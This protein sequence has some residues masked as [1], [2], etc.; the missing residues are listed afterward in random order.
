MKIA[1]LLPFAENFS[2]EKA[3]AIALYCR[4]LTLE[5]EADTQVEIYGKKVANAFADLPFK[6]LKPS[7]FHFKKNIALARS[8]L[9]EIEKDKPDIIE[10]HNRPNIFFYLVKKTKLPTV[11]VLHN[12]PLSMKELKSEPSR[13]KLLQESAMVFCVSSFVKNRLLEGIEDNHLSNKVRVVYN[14]IK[15]RRPLFPQ[16]SKNI[17]FVGR[18]IEEKGALEFIQG[19]R[20]V[21]NQHPEWSVTMIGAPKHGMTNHH[22]DKYT[23]SVVETIKDIGPQARHL[24]FLDYSTVMDHFESASIVVVPSIWK[25]PLGRT[26]IEAL[27]SGA[28]LLSSNNGGLAEINNG[29]GATLDMVSSEIIATELEKLLSSPDRLSE[30]QHRCW[31][32]FDTFSNVRI[33]RQLENH[34][35]EIMSGR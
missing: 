34:R 5:K 23:M 33:A 26:A 30:L 21:L 32:R 31:K 35:R 18:I 2:S 14:G 17:L 28:A 27:A 15:R 24:G 1:T 4:D 19:C 7:P 29:C 11:L 9:K 12:D 8:F 22:E 6:G 25:E 20:P 16:K 13:R 3:G 10:I